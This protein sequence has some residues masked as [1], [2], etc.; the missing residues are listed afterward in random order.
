M[1]ELVEHRL[2][3]GAVEY[4]QQRLHEGL[5]LSNLLAESINASELDLVTFLPPASD[6]SFLNEFHRGGIAN[7]SRAFERLV[8]KLE[9]ALSEPSAVLVAENAV[10]RRSDPL[11][12]NRVSRRAFYEDE[13]YHIAPS[14]SGRKTIGAT[15]REAES[16]HALTF[17]VAAGGDG[18]SFVGDTDD[19]SLEL[20]RAIA[21][22]LKLVGVQAYDGESYVLGN[23]PGKTD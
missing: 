15:I 7:A 13:V 20:L 18:H 11:L 4:L 6:A 9:K 19:L 22:N 21:V 14:G 1:P 10:A 17:V 5:T 12:K 8:G 16:A 3:P 23:R 2:G